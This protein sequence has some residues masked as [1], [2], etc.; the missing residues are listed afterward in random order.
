MQ[1]SEAKLSENLKQKALDA[2]E[3]VRQSLRLL[4]GAKDW[5]ER[6]KSVVVI[7]SAS[8]SGSSLI[9][10]VLS[11]SEN[12]IAPAGEHEPWLFLSGNKFPFTQS[13]SLPV[14]NDRDYLLKL[15]RNDLLIREASIRS[16][17]FF[18]LAWNR[19]S[20]RGE[21]DKKR[22]LEEAYTSYKNQTLRVEDLDRVFK[23]TKWNSTSN[24]YAEKE[25]MYWPIENPPYIDQPLARRA[26][27]S[28]LSSKT[29]L[30]K[31]PSDAYRPGFYESLFPNA[32]ITYIHLTRGFAQT[33][34]GLMDGWTKDE[35]GFI[36]NPVGILKQLSIEGYSGAG[37]TKNY[38]C[39]D[40]FPDWQKFTDAS[41]VEV[42][43][44]QWL[45]AHMNILASFPTSAQIKF[46][47][48][49]TDRDAFLQDLAHFTA[50]R[51]HLLNWD[52][53]VMSTDKPSQ[54]RWRKREDIFT[55]LDQWLEKD[56]LEKIV[57]MQ[58]KLGYSMKETT[59]H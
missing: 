10:K 45:Q 4:D 24:L 52:Q 23:Q 37:I 26:T 15:L 17:E 7:L 51:P 25:N 18:D 48:F 31:S 42:C 5:N 6:V 12:I 36:S 2:S 56:T 29:L 59:W 32:K 43:A 55:H 34:N 39:F 38:W 41:L 22:L 30:F 35:V 47:S 14:I 19:L 27:D 40:L 54:F 16:E 44:Q 33:V 53:T 11:D 57:E 21:T 46:E 20:V 1:A 3:S 49:Y 13:D 8:R 28:E 50:A 58:Q 9:F